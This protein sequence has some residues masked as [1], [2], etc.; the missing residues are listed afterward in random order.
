MGK[1]PSASPKVGPAPRRPIPAKTNV[2]HLDSCAGEHEDLPTAGPTVIVEP[3]VP[4]LIRFSCPNCGK[5]YAV[6]DR[7]AGRNT[8]CKSCKAA[9][10]IPTP[11]VANDV[12]GESLLLPEV[13]TPVRESSCPACGRPMTAGAVLCVGCGYDRRT[14]RSVQTTFA[15]GATAPR[16]RSAASSAPLALLRQPLLYVALAVL[17]ALPTILWLNGTP[18]AMATMSCGG[19]LAFVCMVWF[20]F[21]TRRALREERGNLAP[22]AGY[23]P[24]VG[25]LFRIL[26]MVKFWNRAP[27]SFDGILLGLFL[28]VCGVA[29][30]THG[31][32]TPVTTAMHQMANPDVATAVSAPIAPPLPAPTHLAPHIDL[33]DIHMT[34]AGP[35]SRE[36]ILLYMPTGEEAPHSVPCVFIAPAG[37]PMITGSL[38]SPGDRAE[39]SPYLYRSF[40]V[41]AYDLDGPASKEPSNREVVDAIRQFRDAQYGVLNGRIAID[42]V[43]AHVPAIDPGELFAAG[44]SSAASVALNLAAND[45]RIRAVAAYAPGVDAATRFSAKAKSALSGY[46]AIDEILA[47]ASPI[48]HINDISCPVLLFHADDD[49]NVTTPEFQRL[50]TGLES[51]GKKVTVATVPDGGHY[52]SM[53]NK[54]IDAGIKFLL[55]LAPNS[56]F[57]GKHA[58]VAAAPAPD[59]AAPLPSTEPAPLPPTKNTAQEP[60]PA[61]PQPSPPAV[62]HPSDLAAQYNIAA[63]AGFEPSPMTV[64]NLRS[65]RRRTTG[66]PPASYEVHFMQAGAPP[67]SFE[68]MTTPTIKA[69][70]IT[71]RQ[72]R[73]ASMGPLHVVAWMAF[74]ANCRIDLLAVWPQNDTAAGAAITEA[75]KQFRR[76][77]NPTTPPR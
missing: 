56:H 63:P 38:L 69:G 76:L 49:D 36:H 30:M 62:P 34:G 24:F 40:A 4:S 68:K 57:L 45:S 21:Q 61:M 74:D 42:Y 32:T 44:H 8:T 23:I 9:L 18:P 25:S 16:A 55:P 10:T 2:H 19:L 52:E 5:R 65:W 72:Y 77:D 7:L 54:G 70:R 43:L 64:P 50:V 12:L 47:A 58:A 28:C 11:E 37:T 3:G 29:M 31:F 67:A 73:A 46:V 1:P 27:V 13:E 53:I 48:N 39:H 66:G 41:V 33:Y 60:A 51:A 22:H 6:D 71:F 17:I 14:R 20:R 35:G 75:I 15:A 59:A 26:Y